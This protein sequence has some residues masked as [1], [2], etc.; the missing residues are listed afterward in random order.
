MDNEEYADKDIEDLPPEI[1]SIENTIFSC[2]P[3]LTLKKSQVTSKR[4]S[5]I[6]Y[7]VFL[8]RF[9]EMIQFL[10]C[11]PWLNFDIEIFWV[12]IQNLVKFRQI[13][14]DSSIWGR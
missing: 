9:Q 5:Y 7:V 12:V 14:T 4:M 11:N 2:D 8:F 13:Q 3:H 10:S 1:D 6:F